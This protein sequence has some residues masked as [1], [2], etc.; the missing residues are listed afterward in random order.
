[1]GKSSLLRTCGRGPL[2]LS[3]AQAQE[4]W[5]KQPRSQTQDRAHKRKAHMRTQD[6]HVHPQVQTQ[7]ACTNTSTRRKTR[8]WFCKG[9]FEPGR[10][11]PSPCLLAEGQSDTKTSISQGKYTTVS[12]DDAIIFCRG[13]VNRITKPTWGGIVSSTLPKL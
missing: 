5:Q 9:C 13:Q 1:M 12:V 6:E 10:Y 7:H 3:Q 4:R 2:P 11:F 8:F